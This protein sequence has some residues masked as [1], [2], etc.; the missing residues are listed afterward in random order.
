MV[1]GANTQS[2]QQTTK[3]RQLEA[4]K[5]PPEAPMTT[6]AIEAKLQSGSNT[7]QQWENDKDLLLIARALIP[8]ESLVSRSSPYSRPDDTKYMHRSDSD[9]LLLKRLALWFKRD[10]M[11]WVNSPKCHFC[12]NT[13][14]DNVKGRGI[15]P[16]ETAE[17]REGGASRVELY[18]CLTCGSKLRFPRYNSCA[19]LLETRQGRCGEFANLFGF[20]CR[21]LG[22]ETRYVLD[23][24]DH[25]WVEVYSHRLD[26]WIMA[27]SCEGKIDEPCM[28][29]KGWGKKLNCIIGFTVDSCM[30]VTKRYTRTFDSDEFQARR[31]ECLGL[32]GGA[33]GHAGSAVELQAVVDRL[34]ATLRMTSKC[35]AVRVAELDRRKTSELAFLARSQLEPWREGGPSEG[36][37]SGSLSW[38]VSRGE[39]GARAQNTSNDGSTTTTESEVIVDAFVPNR[40]CGKLVIEVTSFN[41]TS[42]NKS[43]LP[44]HDAI[45]FAGVP[46]AL[47]KK[48]LNVVIIDET[49]G[50][51]L[52][53]GVFTT[54]KA[55]SDFVNT[56]PDDR[57]I[58]VALLY[59]IKT[60]ESDDD[61][62]SVL[63]AR[64]PNFPSCENVALYIG[65]VGASPVWLTSFGGPS[66]NSKK[67]LSV[68]V[69]ISLRSDNGDNALSLEHSKDTF[70]CSVSTRVP[71]SIMPVGTQIIASEEQKHQA[72]ITALDA[73]GTQYVGYSTKSGHPIYLLTQDCFPLNGVNDCGWK[74]CHYIAEPLVTV[75][76][77]S[78]LKNITCFCI[79]VFM[80]SISSP[81]IRWCVIL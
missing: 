31:R 60:A 8:L 9:V 1:G 13:S 3:P 37:I 17:E 32:L 79:I 33:A 7:A 48:G 20:M 6:Q 27:D 28:Y 52:Q 41:L 12:N 67:N 14:D 71:E 72:A 59:D 54:M 53:R 2:E 65:Q 56:L 70:P 58:A 23:F 29:E 55:F 39:E 73:M 80:L 40:C 5:D 24:T 38:K 34:N 36:R 11:Q 61:S 16:A 15:A 57:I 4:Y 35:S 62:S 75:S 22:F 76:M 63:C 25:V 26:R 66:I 18:Q 64:L 51:V 19:K 74:T 47:G 30:D 50:C 69:T 21:S 44:C 81:Y 46:C 43:S 68:I 10:F 45:S 42:F 49:S 78:K 77:D